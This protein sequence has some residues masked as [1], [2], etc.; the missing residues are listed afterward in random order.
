M[1]VI[2]YTSVT[3]NP[4]PTDSRRT[5]TTTPA[6]LDTFSLSGPSRYLGRTYMIEALAITAFVIWTIGIILA[7][8]AVP[9]VVVGGLCYAFAGPETRMKMIGWAP[10]F[11]HGVRKTVG[12]SRALR[13]RSPEG[14]E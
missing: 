14:A 5:P 6:H 3:A 9:V 1:F 7:M 13:G 4:N 11:H 8:L 10:G 12:L 2:S